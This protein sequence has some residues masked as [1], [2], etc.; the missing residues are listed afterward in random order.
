MDLD[1]FVANGHVHDRLKELGRDIPYPQPAQ[2]LTLQDGRFRDSSAAAG[3]IFSKPLVGRS[4]ATM[5]F[6]HDFKTNI[7]MTCLG[8]KPLLLK[9][10]TKDHG[11]VIK[12]NL[13]GRIRTRHPIGARIELF[14]TDGRTIVRF[15]D[16]STS[17][18]SDSESVIAIGV[19]DEQSVARVQIRWP[20]GTLQTWTS[21][22]VNQKWGL[23]EGIPSALAIP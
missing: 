16:G 14:T 13:I 4:S 19:G 3:E 2:L 5:D 12:L 6:N 7:V 23:V 8:D 21:L 11:N 22:V 10:V 9:N 15:V 18:L 1:L 20:D 17:Y